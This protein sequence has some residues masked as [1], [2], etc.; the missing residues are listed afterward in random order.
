M[1]NGVESNMNR[2]PDQHKAN[3]VDKNKDE[4][5][6]GTFVSVLFIGGV[7]LAMWLIVFY[8]YISVTL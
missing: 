4:H 8:I 7:I 3:Q 1:T 5:L 2:S 6:R